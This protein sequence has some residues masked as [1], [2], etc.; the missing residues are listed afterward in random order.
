MKRF[1][2]IDI[3]TSYAKIVES[4][5]QKDTFTVTNAACVQ[6]P[7]SAILS[8]ASLDRDELSKKLKQIIRDAGIKQNN[9]VVSLHESLV[10]TRILEMPPLSDKE[11]VQALRWE[12][13]R[14][15]P[16]PLDEVN[17]DFTVM[18]KENDHKKM[19]VAIVASPLRLIERYVELFRNAN[20][21]IDALE[22]ESFSYLRLYKDASHSRMIVDFCDMKTGIYVLRKQALVLAR[23]I[24]T[25]GSALTKAIIAEINVPTEK[26]VGYKQTYG[27]DP[28]QLDGRMIGVLSPLLNMITTELAQSITYF[29]ELYPND[30][31]HEVLLTGGGALMPQ[32]APY[33]QNKL[34]VQTGIANPWY[35]ATLPQAVRDRYGKLAQLFS[36]ATGL[37]LR[38]HD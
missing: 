38:E 35:A 10:F 6:L 16:L 15:I 14:Y 28:N 3:G 1:L 9:A 33:V 26:A 25:G 2:G 12:A 20:I 19:S 22:N 18:E 29:K 5:L 17:M 36:V 24:S 30:V 34:Q 21:H 11:L 8:D 7:Q 23:T 13:E 37:T 32:V 4:D 27:L 31:L